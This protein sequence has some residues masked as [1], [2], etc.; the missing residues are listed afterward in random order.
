MNSV[1]ND[2]GASIKM[3]AGLIHQRLGLHYDSDRIDMLSEK[4]NTLVEAGNYGSILDYYYFLKYDNRCAAEWQRL[5]S[6]LAVSETYFWREYD[7]VQAA[8]QILIPEFLRERPGQPVRIWHAGCASGEEA[9]SMAISLDQAGL[10][11]RDKVSIIATDF[12]QVTLAQ[13]RSGEYRQR[14]FRSLP[15][16]IQN[17]YFQPSAPGLYQLDERIRGQVNFIYL[18][19]FDETAM[20]MMFGYDIIFCR[21]VFIYFSKEGIRRVLGML[22]QALNPKGYLMVAAAESLLRITRQFELIEVGNAFVYQKNHIL[23]KQL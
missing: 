2:D 15:E 9:Y 21:N 20:Q 6:V 5:Q 22:Y 19:L 18:N 11:D 3:L 7:Q 17:R 1:R 12:N 4:I 8:V 16:E 13:A 23:D 14:A 10:L